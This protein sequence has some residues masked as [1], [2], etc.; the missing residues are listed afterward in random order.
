MVC[1]TYSP[2][3]WV[4]HARKFLW[5]KELTG[6]NDHSVLDMWWIEQGL[7]WLLGKPWCGLF[8]AEAIEFAGLEAPKHLYRAKAWLKWGEPIKA[9]V[10]GCVVI[11]G[12]KG[13][14]HVAFV[15]GRDPKGRLMCLGGNQANK[16]SI[17]PFDT[18]RVLGYRIPKNYIGRPLGEMLAESES[19]MNE[20]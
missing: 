19:S 17:A 18:S 20:A 13:G 7:R 16:V 2:T 1:L 9:P 3:P 12:R 6:K 11:F 5:L 4:T 14:G 8:V 15:V 10:F